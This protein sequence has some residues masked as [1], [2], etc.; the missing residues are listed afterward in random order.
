MYEIGMTK[1][2][3]GEYVKAL[4][5]FNM[6][7]NLDSVPNKRDV[8]KNMVVAYEMSGDFTSACSVMEEYV[9]MYPQDTAA[10]RELTF[11]RTR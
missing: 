9:T 4:E 1:M 3:R 7:M 6:A 11:L 2:E 8:M 10:A 5:Y